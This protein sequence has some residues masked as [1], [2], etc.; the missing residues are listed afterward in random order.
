VLGFDISR[1]TG[2][3]YVATVI[4]GFSQL[5]TIDLFTGLVTSAQPMGTLTT[6][7]TDIAVAPAS[8]L[9]NTSVR[10]RVELRQRSW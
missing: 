7:V 8:R 5:L 2:D 4:A 3:A 9:L 6:L 1:A 10:G